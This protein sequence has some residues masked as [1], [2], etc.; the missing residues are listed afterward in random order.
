MA[1]LNK[2][3]S[4]LHYHGDEGTY[5]V[6]RYYKGGRPV[7]EAAVDNTDPELKIYVGKVSATW[8]KVEKLPLGTM[9]KLFETKGRAWKRDGE[10]HICTTSMMSYICPRAFAILANLF[11]TPVKK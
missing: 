10:D 2:I 7:F 11:V 5:S 6:Y 3:R 9:G 4:G 1:Q 8:A